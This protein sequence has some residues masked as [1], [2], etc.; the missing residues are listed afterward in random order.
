[1]IKSLEEACAS[2]GF[3]LEDLSLIVPHQA[4]GRIIEAIS[5]RLGA[6]GKRVVNRVRERGNTSS[7]Y[8]SAL[9]IR[10]EWAIKTR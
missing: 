6:S 2:S 8:H 7:M 9:F 4:N 1:M 5:E 10:F 3:K